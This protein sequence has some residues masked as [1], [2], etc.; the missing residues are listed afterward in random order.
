MDH[1]NKMT[2]ID[3]SNRMRILRA[4]IFSGVLIVGLG[5]YH[6]AAFA[7]VI[8][9]KHDA[10]GA[11]TG[12]SWANAFTNLQSALSVAV[13]ESEIWVAKG[14]YWPGS[15]R[16][17]SFVLPSGVMLYGGFDG[18]ETSL[19][20]RN[21]RTNLTVLSGEIGSTNDPGDNAFHVVIGSSGAFLDGFTVTGGYADGTYP[22]NNGAG[23]FNSNASPTVA[24]CTFSNN[25]TALAGSGAG[26]FN[27]NSSP[28]IANCTFVGN[29]GYWGGGICNLNGASPVI[30]NCLFQ[31]NTADYGAGVHSEASSPVIKNCI[32]SRNSADGAGIFSR[33]SSVT[34]D[35]CAFATNT[36]HLWNGGGIGS[37]AA[38]TVAQ[39]CLLVG[40]TASEGRGAG[41]NVFRGS[42]SILN[43][44]LVAN[45][46]VLNSGGGI[47]LEYSTASSI[48]N[49]I[50]WSNAS[51]LT[52]AE[53]L[54]TNCVVT[55]AYSD[56]DGGVLG[57]KC[58]GGG[59]VNGGGNFGSDPRFVNPANPAG[60]DGV[61]ATADDGLC[62]DSQLAF[63]SPCIDAATSAD[64]PSQDI[65]GLSRPR[66]FGYD[67]GAYEYDPDFDRDGL[68]NMLEYRLGTNPRSADSD[69]DGLSDHD[70]DDIYGTNPAAADTDGDGMPDKWEV[71]NGL[72]PLVNDATE[73]RDLDGLTNLQEYQNRA[74]GYRANL[75]DSLSD[76]SSDYERLLGKAPERF[77]YDK[78]DRL[79]GAEYNHGTRGF[80]IAYF[81][82]GNGNIKRQIQLTRD[83][84][85]NGLPDLWEALKGLTN[86]ASAFVDSDGD[87][88]SD[89]QE[90]KGG[91]NPRDASS[92]PT[93]APQT[94]PITS[95]LPDPSVGSGL[96]TNLIRLWDAEGN[97]SWVEMR[98]QLSGA[99]NWTNVTIVSVDGSAYG[100]ASAPPTGLTHQVVWNAAERLGVGVTTN[101]LL[102]AR[103]SDL[104]QTGG[105]SAPI[106]YQVNTTAPPTIQTQPVSV[107][108]IVGTTASFTVV[109]DGIGPLSYQWRHYGTNVPSGTLQTLSLPNVQIWQAG[110]YSVAVSNA[111]GQ[112]NSQDA[113]LTVVVPPSITAQP[114]N[115]TNNLGSSATFTVT[116]S[117]TEPLYFQWKHNG[118]SLTNDGNVSG[119]TTPA[120][121]VNNLTAA[122]AGNYLVTV[123]NA[124]GTTNSDAAKLTVYIAPI[125]TSCTLT[126]HTFTVTFDGVQGLYYTLECKSL[127]DAPGWTPLPD[128]VLGTGGTQTLVDTNATPARKF[129][130][131]KVD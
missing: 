3:P 73:D 83:G 107:T 129:Y 106:E 128:P 80:A 19:T 90:W 77:Y 110:P 63:V 53:I 98:F 4:A 111:A 32:F 101:L 36:A 51:L 42:A 78:A 27:Y 45:N 79:V 26:I 93:N 12:Q 75:A 118:N 124:A 34:I 102:Q 18:T 64:A 125:I 43:C 61:F 66:N 47:S 41:V 2:S 82:D 72:N 48:R 58:A 84:N 8:H 44:T 16:G 127:V 60:P 10:V 14:T 49:T 131:I 109:A 11:N 126:G 91:S 67:V 119:A 100:A 62:L 37:V 76:G 130:R 70:E 117:G 17:T 69:G 52:G 120:L 86:N 25:R 33:D 92:V 15:A 116:A 74:S 94:A 35:A 46:A 108:N 39:N 65:I 5:A 23:L 30:S 88:W 56:V 59:V 104:T 22:H 112:T 103:A 13:G 55:V 123:T 96:A 85:G 113:T 99:T 1:A 50:F 6:V 21:W 29:S 71:D 121:T 97:S 87:G 7:V 38:N 68:P 57:A 122:D 114:Q 81:Y 115:R 31:A 20:N 24:N 9:V 40:N 28:V 54:A 95:I 89:Y 105:W